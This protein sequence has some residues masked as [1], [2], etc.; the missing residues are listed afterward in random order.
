MRIILILAV[1]MLPTK[2]FSAVAI[3]AAGCFWCIEKDFEQ[4]EGVTFVESGYIGGTNENPTYEK[5]C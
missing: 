5:P 2:A 3:L 1:L 4:V